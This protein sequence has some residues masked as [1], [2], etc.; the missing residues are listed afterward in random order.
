M[1]KLHLGCGSV[2]LDGWVNVD[3]RWTPATDIVT[4]AR[5]LRKWGP[6]SVDSIYSCHCL[7]HCCRWEIP[8]ILRRWQEVLK[9]GGELWLSVPDF[10]AVIMRYAETNDLN[11][12]RGLLYGG[13]DWPGNEHRTIW[14]YMTL[15]AELKQAGFTKVDSYDWREGP[16][17]DVDDYSKAY[18][19]HLDQSGRLMSLNVVAVK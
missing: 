12:L 11:E 14:D 2:H 10:R 5:Y 18:L 1:V 16:A 19:P 6:E 7:E 8:G 3:L 13:Q 4:D 17:K 9:P 15:K